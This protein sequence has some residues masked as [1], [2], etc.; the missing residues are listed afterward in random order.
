MTA[1]APTKSAEPR[2]HKRNR[3][4]HTVSLQTGPKEEAR[5]VEA[6]SLD[7]SYG[8]ISVRS[9]A[10]M[11]VGDTLDVIL[12]NQSVSIKGR[13]RSTQRVGNRDYRVGV[14]FEEEQDVIVDIALDSPQPSKTNQ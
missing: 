7:L 4:E 11:P 10:P 8:G 12:L 3:F 5:R 13:V 14:A 1:S 6:E 9:Q 2:N